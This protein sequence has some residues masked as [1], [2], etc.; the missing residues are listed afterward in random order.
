M[1]DYAR[2]LPYLGFDP[3][4]GDV[5]LT[6]DLARR[7][8]QVAQETRRIL[9][10]VEKLDLIPWQ[11]RAGD[12][13][14]ALKDTF[15]PALRNSVSAAETLQAATSSWADQLSGFQAEA[16]ALE[17]KA[18]SAR[19]HQ[20]ALRTQRAALPPSSSSVL[21][22][23]LE[24]VSASLAA[25][26]VQAL[27]LHERYLTAAQKTAAGLEGVR[28]LWARA[29]PARTV[30]EAVLAPLDI[31]AADHWVEALKKVAGV[32]ES[33]VKQVDK[34]IGD[35]TDAVQEDKSPAEALI[36]AGYIAES[37]GNKIDAWY[38]FAPGWLKNAAGSLAEIKG[39]SS[40]LSGL[41]IVADVGT[42]FSPQDKG[43]LGGADRVVAGF[44]GA[45]LT[46]N[47]ALD[48][49][50]GPGEVMLAATGAYLA[51]D[52]IF[53]H[54]ALFVDAAKD[55]GHAVVSDVDEHVK[56]D[57]RLAKDAGHAASALWHSVTSP[58]GSWF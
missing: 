22:G 34:A 35:I 3:A 19:A 46:A 58:I 15:P 5:R 25:V 38:A 17:R 47:I 20:Q 33:W 27:E 42:V 23:D 30:L 48:E 1:N 51:G 10:M 53:H 55:I 29:E 32:P 41:G 39:L 44:N 57:I 50:P 45:L 21:K 7:H 43:G 8:Y 37:A 16:D 18:A 2:S 24:E 4:A 14:R 12:A 13:M 11:G 26:N 56:A 31:V 36:E 49:L 54:R 40:V 9:S 6:H 28:H 52:F